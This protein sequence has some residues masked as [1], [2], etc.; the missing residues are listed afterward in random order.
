MRTFAIWLFY[1]FIDVAVAC[2]ATL[3][4]DQQPLLPFFATLAILWVG[5]P[6]VGLLWLIKF[7][8]AYW[9]FLKTRMVRFYKAEMFKLKFPSSNGHFDWNQYLEFVMT[10]QSVQKQAAV[11]AGVFAG[12]IEGFRTTR[13]FTMFIAAQSSFEQAMSEYQAPPSTTGS[14]PL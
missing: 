13:P 9:L 12:E 2:L 7:W 3:L 14:N 10:D 6:L 8:L 11:K 5:L 4:N 1:I